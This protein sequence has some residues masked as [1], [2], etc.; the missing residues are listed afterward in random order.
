MTNECKAIFAAINELC[1]KLI[2]QMGR[3]PAVDDPE[4]ILLTSRS[5]TVRSPNQEPGVG[6]SNLLNGTRIARAD[7]FL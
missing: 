1:E 3:F 4:V 5:Q 2:Q 7:W 6:C